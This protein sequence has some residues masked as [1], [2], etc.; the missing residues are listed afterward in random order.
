MRYEDPNVMPERVNNVT[1][2]NTKFKYRTNF[3]GR[4]YAFKRGEK[5]QCIAEDGGKRTANIAIFDPVLASD[6]AEEGWSV[7]WDQNDNAY[8]QVEA[9]YKYQPPK[10][11]IRVSG[12]KKVT[13]LEE[14][15][16]ADIDFDEVESVDVCLRGRWWFDDLRQNRWRLKAW[17]KTMVVTIEADDIQYKYDCEEDPEDSEEVPFE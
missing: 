7:Q 6:L 13:W 14:D 10:I 11:G 16:I 15:D 4:Q 2:E 8:I 12:K 3:A 1:I 9:G 17:I 5:P